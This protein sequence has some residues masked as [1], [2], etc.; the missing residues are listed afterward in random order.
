MT[1]LVTILFAGFT[2]LCSGCHCCEG[3]F[4][5]HKEPYYI[6]GSYSTPMYGGVPVAAGCGC[7]AAAPAG[8]IISQSP[9]IFDQTVPPPVISPAGPLVPEK[10]M[11][12]AQ[13]QPMPTYPVSQLR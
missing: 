12:S 6:S 9:P 3:W 5:K 10:K 13:Y 7:G 2:A 1:R 8:V 11:P 4:H